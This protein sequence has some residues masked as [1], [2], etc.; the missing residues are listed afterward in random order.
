MS[1][2]NPALI[3]F[4]FPKP[5][6]G[7]SPS[8]YCQK[9]ETFLR[10]T[11]TPHE[12][13]ETQPNLA[14]KGKLP[15]VE[16]LH[17]DKTQSE[18]V[19]DSH[20][21][22]R[23]LISEGISSDPDQMAGLTQAQK[24]D[25]RAW[26]AYIEET[27]Y[28]SILYERWFVDENYATLVDELFSTIPWPIRP[29]FAWSFRRIVRKNLWAQGMG[30]HSVEEVKVLQK[31]A[32]DALDSRLA[33]RSYFH[34]DDKPSM[35]DLIMFA[36]VTNSLGT[37]ANPYW[38]ELLLRSSNIVGFTKRLTVLLFAEYEDVLRIL[39]EAETRMSPANGSTA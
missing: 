27:V 12:L 36:F 10:F 2:K 8:G 17:H 31:E 39:E 7:P 37:K 3:L 13:R 30:R 23:H 26:Q 21:I 34:G 1:S 16:I 24:A 33:E 9:A 5:P 22:I 25:S 38:T 35:I 4:G 11:A 28:F 19:P 29:M 32:V 15:Y 20:F 18:I 6:N 14:P